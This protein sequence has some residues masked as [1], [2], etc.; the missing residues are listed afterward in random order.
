MALIKTEKE[1]QLLREGGKR[2]AF[3]LSE[4]SKAVRPGMST[5][6]IDEMV[7]R[8]ITEHGDKPSFLGYTPEGADRP[9]PASTCVSVNED[10]IH[11]IPNEEPRIL[12]EGDIVSIDIG[13]IH[14]GM[15]TDSAVTVAVGKID[16]ASQ[17]L[18]RATKEALDAGIKA[19]K[20]GNHIG[21]IGYAVEKVAKKYHFSLAEDLAGHGVGNKVHEDPFVPN[22]GDRG[23]GPLLKPGMVLAIEPMLNQGTGKIVL[24]KDG[25]TYRTADM[26]RS[27]HFEHTV[28]ITEGD[29]VILTS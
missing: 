20:G 15:F 6:E 8:L 4:V 14:K 12:K 29:P 13:L 11:G 9:F 22:Y 1:I 25:Y 2:H 23:D 21:D 5:L 28:L 10:I 26:K 18:L 17:T 24:K 7:Y 19:A 16:D 3:I 27:A